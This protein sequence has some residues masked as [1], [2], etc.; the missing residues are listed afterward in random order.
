[1]IY[2]GLAIDP[3]TLDGEINK[4]YTFTV[5]ADNPPANARYSWVV[6]NA[7]LQTDAQKTFKTTFKTTGKHIVQVKLLDASGKELQKAQ[8]TANIKD[9]VKLTVTPDVLKGE[10]GKE[11]TFNAYYG[12]PSHRRYHLRMVGERRC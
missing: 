11:Y 2:G 6:D 10:T 3:L 8:S 12:E 4:E 5:K 7:I 1:M 9:A